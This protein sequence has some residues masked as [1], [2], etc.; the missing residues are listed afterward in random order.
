MIN[1]N[2]NTNIHSKLLNTQ[3]INLLNEHK[4]IKIN[5]VIETTFTIEYNIIIN[6]VSIFDY[7][8]ISIS[9]DIDAGDEWGLIKGKKSSHS[10]VSF[11]NPNYPNE[12]NFN[13]V[14]DLKFKS[15]NIQ[16]WP[17]IIFKIH[18][19]NIFGIKKELCYGSLKLPMSNGKY[20]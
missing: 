2:K 7:D 8:N 13:F 10:N 3:N 5:N 6:S 12:I 18:Y 9:Y 20:I 15:S 14:I 19:L 11:L 4:K 17:I 16:N 1:I